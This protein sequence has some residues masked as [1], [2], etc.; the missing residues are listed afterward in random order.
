MQFTGHV[1]FVF[2]VFKPVAEYSCRDMITVWF[3][4]PNKVI[5]SYFSFSNCSFLLLPMVTTNLLPFSK[6]CL[7]WEFHVYGIIKYVT[8]CQLVLV[9][10]LS[11]GT[12]SVVQ[13]FASLYC[14]IVLHSMNTSHMPTYSPA[15][16]IWA[17]SIY[18]FM[19]DAVAIALILSFVISCHPLFQ[20]SWG[21]LGLECE[22]APLGSYV[23]YLVPSWKFCF[24]GL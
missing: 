22:V 15:D 7:S 2:K 17:L 8:F 11:S 10:V 3:S 12:M 6:S 1:T 13:S 4:S 9:S 5:R 18:A 23:G 14:P 19:N 20:F 16:G 24:W 21:L